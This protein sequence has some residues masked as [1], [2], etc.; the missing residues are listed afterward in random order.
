LHEGLNLAGVFDVGGVF[1]CN[2]SRWAV[3]I[4]WQ[5]QTA[6]EDIAVKSD[7]YGFEGVRVDGMDPLAVY[8]TTRYALRKATAA[9]SETRRPTLIEALQ[10]RFGPHT[11]A[12]DP[13]VYRS[14]EELAYWRARDPI[15]R[16][17]TFLQDRGLLDGETVET[18]EASTRETVADAIDTAESV[19]S[20]PS[21]MFDHVYAEPTPRIEAQK[22][23]LTDLL[24][25]YGDDVFLGDH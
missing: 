21:D 24:D 22:R 15:S 19:E 18:I 4:P 6:S 11:T 13:S 12:D 17:E 1:F 23:E 10:Y 2:D 8:A 5:K 20:D 14:D 7:A 16:F 25:E 9:D 3:A